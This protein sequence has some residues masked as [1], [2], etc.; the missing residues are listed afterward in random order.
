MAAGNYAE[1]DVTAIALAQKAADGILTLKVVSNGTGGTT[2]ASF[3]SKEAANEA[4]RPSLEYA[5]SLPLLLRMQPP[6]TEKETM[7]AGTKI[8]PNPAGSY[9]RVQTDR[10]YDRAE[11]R[12][13][14]GRVVKVLVLQGS[15]QFEID[16]QQVPPGL[17]MLLLSGP[18]GTELRKIVKL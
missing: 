8:F 6:S 5:S 15:L 10:V 7:H 11:L 12:D 18:K 16:L 1:W 17:Y 14:S 9:A 4:Q 2:D 3:A 13:I